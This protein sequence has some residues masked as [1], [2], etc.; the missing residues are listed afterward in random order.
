MKTLTILC[1]LLSLATA[2]A[3]ASRLRPRA[4]PR[5]PA[6]VGACYTNVGACFVGWLDSVTKAQCAALGGGSW[7]RYGG[8]CER[9]RY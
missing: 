9:L 4:K 2:N 7:A 5:R 1:L 8:G 3:E 6:P